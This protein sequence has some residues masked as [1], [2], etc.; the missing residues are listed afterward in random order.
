MSN[1]FKEL[2]QTVNKGTQELSTAVRQAVVKQTTE[3]LEKTGS[4]KENTYEMAR[5]AVKGATEA[6]HAGKEAATLSYQAITGM[7]E[8]L[9]KEGSK[10]LHVVSESVS[11]ALHG[12]ADVGHDL[13][14]MAK[15]SVK[16][17]LEEAAHL[18]ADLTQSVQGAVIGAIQGVKRTG[19]D[20][21]DTLTLVA[22]E[23]LDV[24]KKTGGDLVAAGKGLLNGLFHVSQEKGTV[25][26]QQ[27]KESITHS[28]QS[29]QQTGG[30]LLASS[31]ELSKHAFETA[32]HLGFG[33]MEPKKLAQTIIE[34]V[35]GFGEQIGA[36]A[37]LL[38]KEAA[39]GM[40]EV[41]E[42]VNPTI[43]LSL[44]DALQPYLSTP[45][46]K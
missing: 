6:G 14:E 44:K 23:A 39:L 20:L 21:L 4:L 41:I 34:I 13:R 27:L 25:A 38:A 17:S 3:I 31:R 2:F 32:L 33:G 43:A 16:G 11:G 12:A 36:N 5:G 10:P 46:T 15:T 45:A 28:L 8:G 22:T 37:G 26:A 7:M 19:G 29:V 35:I 40:V 1:F 18:G 42:R 24:T 9:L 30:D